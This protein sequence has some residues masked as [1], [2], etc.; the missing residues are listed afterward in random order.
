MY[1]A[2]KYL[3]KQGLNFANSI[4]SLWQFCK[5]FAKIAADE[6]V[7]MALHSKRL[8][9]YTYC[10]LHLWQLLQWPQ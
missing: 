7:L 3:I 8:A 6:E 4:H 2:Q 1:L 5:I 9:I 10:H